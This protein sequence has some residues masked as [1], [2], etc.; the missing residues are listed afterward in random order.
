MSTL[1]GRMI[2]SSGMTCQAASLSQPM[3]STREQQI[4]PV[5]AGA[6]HCG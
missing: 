3:L 6:E 1:A 5:A 4:L 2:R